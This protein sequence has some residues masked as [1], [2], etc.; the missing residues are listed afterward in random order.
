MQLKLSVS[1]IR[2]DEEK[3]R[4]DGD[5]GDNDLHGQR[6][7]EKNDGVHVELQNPLDLP[8]QC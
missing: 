3:Q 6:R 2:S 7:F 1:Q 8:T 4:H 5:Y